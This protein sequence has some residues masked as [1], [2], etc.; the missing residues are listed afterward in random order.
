MLLRRLAKRVVQTLR[1]FTRRETG[2]TSTEYAVLLGV[3]ILTVMVSISVTGGNLRGR[4]NNVTSSLPVG[5]VGGDDGGGGYGG[6]GYGGG[7]DGDDD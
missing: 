4:F 1:R 2:P 6:G 5:E 7:D 3:V